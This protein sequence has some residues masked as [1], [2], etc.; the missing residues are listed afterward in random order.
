MEGRAKEENMEIQIAQ[1]LNRLT[2]GIFT[3]LAHR[4]QVARSQGLNVIDL[5]VG[6]PDLPPHP[7]VM[8]ALRE[9]AADGRQYGYTLTGIPRF[10][11]AAAEFYQRRYGVELDPSSEVLQVMGSQD[12]LA[13]LAMALINEG[14]LV[15]VPDPGYPIYEVGVMIAGGALYAMPLEEE[16]GFLPDL[17]QIPA[18]VAA[19]AK[20]MI[21]NYPGNPVTAL[22]DMAFFERLVAFA[23]KHEIMVVHDF[24]YSELVFDGRRPPSFLSVPGAKDVGIEFNSLSKT[25]N[26]AGCRIGYVMGNRQMI[27]AIALL[28]SHI[29]YGIFLPIQ[30]AAVAALE[31]DF[32][33]LEK[34][35]QVYQKRRDILLDALAEAGWV[36]TKPQATMFVWAKI[37]PGWQSRAFAYALLEQTGVAVTPGDAFGREGEG[38]VRIAL[39]QPAEKLREAAGRIKNFSF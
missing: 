21:V 2:T 19:K 6:S 12:G 5:S 28:K 34:N 17:D 11:R 32:K 33:L 8:D 20:M 36:I 22:A 3:E 26:M 15:L 23:K 29:D 13:H 14:E 7:S 37:P 39:V 27:E 38:Y 25:F 35:A 30:K 1:R 31:A 16:N 18:E 24:A 9:N 4:K 10:K